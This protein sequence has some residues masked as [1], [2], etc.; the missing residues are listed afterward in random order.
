VIEKFKPD[1]QQA[2]ELDA[3]DRLAGFRKEFFIPDDT[4]Y[5]NGNSLG[6]MCRDSES[7]LLRVVREW[8]SLGVKGWMEANPPWF[9]YSER[10]GEMAAGLVGAEPEEV[11][12]TGSTTVNIHSV[13]STFFKPDKWRNKILADSLSFPSDIYALKGQLKIRG[14]DPEKYLI[15]VPSGDGKVLNEDQIVSRMGND[16]RLVFLSSV[17]FRSGQLLDIPYLT[18]EAHKRKIL[19]GFDCSHSVGA[20]PHQ[21]SHWGVDFALWCSYKYLNSGPGSSAFLYIN[22]KHFHK[23]PL[24]AG[25]FG[26]QK[27]KQFDFSLRFEPAQ[28]AGGWQISSPGILAAAATEGALKLISRAGLY[29]IREKSRRL[30]GYL[31]FLVKHFLSGKPYGFKIITPEEPERR[32]G[33]VAIEREENLMEIY[34]VLKS[35]RVIPDFRPP[36]LL[37]FSPVALYNTFHQIWFTV[38]TL[39]YI[40][41]HQEYRNFSSNPLLIP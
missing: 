23:E 1:E 11:V 24:L 16:I 35:K 7:C 20:V 40:I 27:E 29:N 15:L 33:H 17:L 25:W 19:I 34:Q 28:Q 37:R 4:V 22:R 9:Y 5:L 2:L 3:E 32:G 26:C 10:L 6:L 30:T 18:G 31:I 21:F 13:I 36:N 14:L 8:K 41:D 38:H 39:K 12:A